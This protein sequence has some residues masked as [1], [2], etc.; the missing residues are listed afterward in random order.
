MYY[1]L[2]DCPSFDLKQKDS[3]VKIPTLGGRQ[4]SKVVAVTTILCLMFGGKLLYSH[5][6]LR[7]MLEEKGL[8]E[9]SRCIT[10]RM[11]LHGNPF[12]SGSFV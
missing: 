6:G 5:R 7:G 4:W 3:S 8:V 10:V 12:L 9:R 11:F 1:G 2:V